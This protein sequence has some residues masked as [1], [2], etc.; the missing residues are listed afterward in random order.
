MRRKLSQHIL[1]VPTAY[2][3]TRRELKDHEYRGNYEQRQNESQEERIEGF[4][5]SDVF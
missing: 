2:N 3:L 1:L 4:C 5:F